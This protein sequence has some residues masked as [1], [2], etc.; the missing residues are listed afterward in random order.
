MI[1]QAFIDDSV[2]QLKKLKSQAD[3]AL[4]QIKGEEWFQP[5]DSESNSIAVIMKHLAGN[6]KSRWTDF[7]TSDGEKPA[8][9]RDSEFENSTVA[10]R[11]QILEAWEQ[12]WAAAIAAV[13]SLKPDDLDR[14]ITIRGEPHSVLEA[15]NRQVTHYA[16]HV[17]QIVL[18]AKH[19][20][21]TSWKTLSI[22]RGKSK[23]FDVSKGGEP[24]KL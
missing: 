1:E 21:G 17:G 10:A 20:A 13:S 8:R 2:L 22:P 11:E 15:V 19:Y 4:A 18:L 7:L 9:N 6:M 14:T 3:R 24:Y 23:D 16:G 5:L 12:G